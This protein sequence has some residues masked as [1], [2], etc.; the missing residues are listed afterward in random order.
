M[1]VQKSV[2]TSGECVDFLTEKESG[3]LETNRPILQ[4]ALERCRLTGATL[5]VAKLDRLSRDAA[6]VLSL[7]G[8]PTINIRALD[9]PED[10]GVTLGIFTVIAQHERKMISQRT[11]RALA[12]KK[13]Q[14]AKLGNPN[15]ADAIFRSGQQSVHGVAAIKRNAQDRAELLRNEVKDAKAEGRETLADIAQ[16]L[17]QRSIK[18]PRGGKW[19]STSVRRLLDRLS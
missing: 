13:E 8:D 4:K 6:F 16:W 18:T 3:K 17:N 1:G 11:K 12:A 10:S 15:G 19:H 2:P 5:L 9:V 7:D 14:G